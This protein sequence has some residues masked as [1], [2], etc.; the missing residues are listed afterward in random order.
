[1]PEEASRPDPATSC[2][3][4]MMTE[5]RVMT[6]KRALGDIDF[7]DLLREVLAG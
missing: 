6:G 5:R 2:D 7:D 4:G 3:A 1:V